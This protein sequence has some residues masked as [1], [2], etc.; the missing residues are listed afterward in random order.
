MNNEDGRCAWSR[1]STLPPLSSRTLHHPSFMS[2]YMSSGFGR[3][4]T[5]LNNQTV[6]PITPEEFYYTDPTISCGARIPN[7][8]TELE[9]FNCFQLN[10]PPPI[11]SAC[12]APP[13]RRDP[14]RAEPYSTRDL[15][16]PTLKSSTLRPPVQ[17]NRVILELT[18]EEDQAI[19]NLLKLRHQKPVQRDETLTGPQMDLFSE[20]LDPVVFIDPACMDFTS[21]EEEHE[22]LCGDVQDPREASWQ[23][24]MHWSDAELEVANTLLSHFSLME[25]DKIWGQNHNKSA[26]ALPDPPLHQQHDDSPTSTDTQQS[27]PAL[28]TECSQD[29]SSYISCG[30]DT[31]SEEADWRDF[32]FVEKMNADDVH[33][34]VC[35]SPPSSASKSSLSISGDFSEL[36]E[37]MLSD[38]EGDAVKV[39]LSLGDTGASDV[40]Q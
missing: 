32:V 10:T 29:D 33:L 30:C 9:D 3:N 12:L 4:Y 35:E 16:N 20:N 38:S 37:W 7:I 18:Q 11:M 26:A 39:L 34:P 19:T 13:T 22:P 27:F 15:G 17:S 5:D 6:H 21:A 24:G 28:A 1:Q 40:M 36:N 14:F 31:E 2:L 23:Q 8:V 25:E